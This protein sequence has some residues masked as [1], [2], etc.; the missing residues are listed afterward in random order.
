MFWE[1]SYPSNAEKGDMMLIQEQTLA[2]AAV[3][4]NASFTSIALFFPLSPLKL[5]SSYSLLLHRGELA[6][7]K[8]E[9]GNGI[10]KEDLEC[11]ICKKHTALKN[12][13]R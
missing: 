6:V 13:N 11:K 3:M 2:C 1:M 12:K 8:K 5:L 4:G 10:I 9:G 7:L